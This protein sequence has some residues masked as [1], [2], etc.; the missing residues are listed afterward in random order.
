M[1]SLAPP[2]LDLMSGRP[3]EKAMPKMTD[4]AFFWRDNGKHLPAVQQMAYNLLVIPVMSS[5]VERA[6]SG[7]RNTMDDHRIR[8]GAAIFEVAELE[9]QWMRAGLGD[10]LGPSDLAGY[11]TPDGKAVLE[12]MLWGKEGRPKDL[13]ED[14]EPI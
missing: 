2:L 14:V 3:S 10:D 9:K 11:L 4:P 5:E 8:L 13:D 7:A 1:S 12:K 6:F